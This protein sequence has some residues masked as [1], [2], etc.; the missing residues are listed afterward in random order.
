MENTNSFLGRG[1]AF[2]PAFNRNTRSVEL[3]EDE[4]DILN[5]LEIL[6]ST[7]RNERIMLPGYGC[8]PDELLFKPLDLALKTYL[9]DQIKTAILY[10]EPRIDVTRV[11]MEESGM[12]DGVVLIKVE[13][14]V[15]KTNSRKNMVYP[16]YK[17]EGNEL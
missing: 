13:F 16:F 15:R 5:S 1:W 7:R 2:P 17:N 14:V 6:L 8:N 9:A 4:A 11:S 12:Q 3:V 10:H